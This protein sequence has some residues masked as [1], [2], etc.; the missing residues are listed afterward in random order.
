MKKTM[1]HKFA[2]EWRRMKK[3]STTEEL[4]EHKS[5]RIKSVT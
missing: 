1:L 4:E 2:V 3:A 5:S